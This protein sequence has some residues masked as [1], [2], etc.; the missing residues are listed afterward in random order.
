MFNT[1][2]FEA[3]KGGALLGLATSISYV[4]IGRIVGMSGLMASL[5]SFKFGKCHP[6]FR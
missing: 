4:V 5:I 6:S 3:I 1:S 2:L